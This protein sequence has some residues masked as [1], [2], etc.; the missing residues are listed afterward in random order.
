MASS[1]PEG[2]TVVIGGSVE[3][4]IRRGVVDG[5]KK[6]TQDGGVG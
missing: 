5:K 4:L 3:M 2:L 1:R 6:L